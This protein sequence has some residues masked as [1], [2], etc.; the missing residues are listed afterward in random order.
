MSRLQDGHGEPGMEAAAALGSHC[1]SACLCSP[2]IAGQLWHFSVTTA[3]T[4][5]KGSARNR[6]AGAEQRLLVCR[7]EGK[8]ML[9]VV[10][11]WSSTH[12]LRWEQGSQIPPKAAEGLTQ[13][14]SL[15]DI[16]PGSWV[17]VCW[18]HTVLPV[19]EPRDPHPI[20]GGGCWPAFASSTQAPLQGCSPTC[21]PCPWGTAGRARQCF[22]WASK[23]KLGLAGRAKRSLLGASG[24]D[25]LASPG[26]SEK[27]PLPVP[28]LGRMELQVPP[29]PPKPSQIML[30]ETKGWGT[31]FNPA[32]GQTALP[33]APA[34][35]SSSQH[36]RGCWQR[37]F[38]LS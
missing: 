11:S 7:E 26:K 17:L 32:W 31:D 12:H 15:G 34:A 13:P 10:K 18:S 4:S 3:G 5:A 38:H 37:T 19:W 16:A 29:N 9:V 14:F 22:T 33:S 23:H 1:A 6:G 2:Y 35:S 21:R 25:R 36:P 24:G 28:S 27:M 20:F 8:E 30:G